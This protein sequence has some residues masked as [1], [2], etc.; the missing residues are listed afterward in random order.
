MK[1]K[2]TQCK[3]NQLWYFRQIGREYIIT[4]TIGS[5]YFKEDGYGIRQSD[6]EIIQDGDD[7]P[8]V[9]DIKWVAPLKEQVGGD[10][11]KNMSIQPVEFI[12]A[13]DLDYFQGNVIKYVCRYK[14]KNG[15]EDLKKAQHYLTMM[16][17]NLNKD[18]RR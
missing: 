3:D 11:Y 6:C 13:N 18:E 10:H 16:Q 5:W 14:Q 8:N 15:I 1:V 2:I 9:D 12:R 4:E 17:E 7:L